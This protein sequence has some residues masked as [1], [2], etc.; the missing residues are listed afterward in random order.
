M[1]I[2]VAYVLTVYFKMPQFM[3]Y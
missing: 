2:K 1:D 3:S